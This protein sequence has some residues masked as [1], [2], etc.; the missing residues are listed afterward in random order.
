MRN[1][2]VCFLLATL[3]E[4]VQRG[5]NPVLEP[6]TCLGI[7]VVFPI[8]GTRLFR[9]WRLPPAV[10]AIAAGAI[11][12]QS[13]LLDTPTLE[14]VSPFRDAGFVWLGIYLGTRISRAP[15]LTVPNAASSI[16][17][18]VSCVL[19]ICLATSVF[20]LT[21]LERLRIG[22][23]GAVCAPVFTMLEPRH[24]R[25]EIGLTGLTTVIGVFL[26][27]LTE[28]IHSLG[29]SAVAAIFVPATAVYIVLLLFAAE[30]AFRATKSAVS[31]PGRY[32]VYILMMGTLW[33]VSLLLDVHPGLMG[34]LFGIV[35]GFRTRRWQDTTAPLLEGSSI[36]GPFVLGFVSAGINWSRLIDA[37]QEA[38]MVAAAI[39]IPMMI[40]KGVAGVVAGKL[41]RFDRQ[42]WLTVYPLGLA[43]MVTLPTV[44]PERLFLGDVAHPDEGLL[45]TLFVGAVVIPIVVC[46][47]ERI[48]SYV[49]SR[50]NAAASS[51]GMEL[52]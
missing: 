12:G 14:S 17:I 42:Q 15:T 32:L 41:T 21:L 36:A 31:G 5:P 34:G 3:A 4:L 37:P 46:L 44:I 6:A 26:L 13:D 28:V 47:L 10:G 45:P 8:L 25:D 16:S 19:L 18:V 39:V 43:A 2:F 48:G 50:R 22:L 49:A 30:V 38:W 11:L 1:L 33:R 20:P 51:G 27:G 29:E 23:A 24:H 35:F 7:L 52:T 40:G 9:N